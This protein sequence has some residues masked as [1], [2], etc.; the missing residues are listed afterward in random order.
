MPHKIQ[1]YG[2]IPD[3]LDHRDHWYA[4]TLHTADLPSSVDLRPHCPPVWDQGQL[5]ACSSHAVCAAYVFDAMKEGLSPFMPSRLMLY[6]DERAL[7]GTIAS[8]SGAMLR[9][10]IKTLANQ[11]VCA[12]SEWPYLI[13]QFATKPPASCYTDGLQHRAITYQRVPQ[14]LGQMRACLAE[15]YP[16]IVGISVYESFESAQV[17]QTGVVPMP[18]PGESLIGGH[19][20]A[21]VGYTPDA[22]ICRNSWSEQWG[23]HGH[24]YLQPEYL[25]SDDLSADFW[26]VRSVR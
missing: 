12:E 17:A 10:G 24:F 15:G 21:A 1:K 25:L 19:A 4:A 23:D 5:G 9:D 8:D 7:E 20:V 11:G 14:N 6:Y 26:T 13:D 18:A 2:Y 3:L 16:I 22:W